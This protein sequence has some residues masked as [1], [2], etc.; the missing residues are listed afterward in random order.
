MPIHLKNRSI[1]ALVAARCRM[2]GFS[3]RTA[4]AYG[5]ALAHF[6]DWCATPAPEATQSQA[7]AWL[8]QI[9]GQVTQRCVYN[10]RAAIVFLFRHLHGVEP[11]VRIIPAC[12]QP[13]P[14]VYEVPDPEDIVRVLAAL[15]DPMYRLHCRFVYATGLRL[16][17][18][19]AVRIEDLDFGS[20]WVVVREGKG[21]RQRRSLLPATIARELQAHCRGWPGKALVF[22]ADG[23]PDGKPLERGN[24]QH[25]LRQTRL[26]LGIQRPITTH[27][28]R[29]AFA[30][31]LHERGV[32]LCELQQLLGHTSPLTTVR[33]I[34]LRER[35]REDILAFADLL[36][37]LPAPRLE[38]QRIAFTA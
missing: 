6:E 32:G 2:L 35:R 15:P 7:A 31:H 33:Y 20:G 11:D 24:V 25:N 23:R 12:R 1:T 34:G 28:L 38:Q 37:A 3:A 17:E 8:A 16:K 27:R 21:A 9:P 5:C 26:R 30:T 10:R 19:M 29:H 4:T 14:A 22:T 13:A 18:S 36:A